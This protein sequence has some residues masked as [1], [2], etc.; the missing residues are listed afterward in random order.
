MSVVFLHI[1]AALALYGAAGAKSG[2]SSH[3]DLT[4]S[5]RPVKLAVVYELETGII[6]HHV[7]EEMTSELERL[8]GPA[9]LQPFF[10]NLHARPPHEIYERLAVARF[11]G[12]C[13]VGPT[14]LESSD[15]PALGITHVS[16]GQ[17]L[18]F[19]AVDCERVQKLIHSEIRGLPVTQQEALFARALARVLAHELYHVVA[20]TSEHG[21]GIQA[22]PKHASALGN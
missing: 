3:P 10:R 1:F 13:S 19:V 8:F 15:D 2:S 17:I 14:L 12:D 21:T 9:A 18:P 11:R 5:S 4:V 22:W 7:F 16:D 20:E 6:G